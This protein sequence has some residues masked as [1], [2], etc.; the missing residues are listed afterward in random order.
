[1]VLS[2]EWINKSIQIEFENFL[3]SC[4]THITAIFSS[5]FHLIVCITQ[6]Q[7]PGNP[8]FASFLG[9]LFFSI[10]QLPLVL[11]PYG[12]YGSFLFLKSSASCVFAYL[13]FFVLTVQLH[14]LL[15]ISLSPP[16]TS[17]R[18][19]KIHFSLFSRAMLY[20]L[21]HYPRLAITSRL[22]QP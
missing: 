18:K 13:S 21:S 7:S 2:Q 22:V 15:P 17:P 12:F 11:L 20:Y 16:F 1:M 10:L 8:N 6:S 19:L 9:T 4:F 5:L 3:Q 14:Q